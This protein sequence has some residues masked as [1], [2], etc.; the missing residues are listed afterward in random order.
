MCL[1]N[2]LTII[3]GI[4]PTKAWRNDRQLNGRPVRQKVA[5]GR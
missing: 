2:I 4:V 5:S 1:L 3:T